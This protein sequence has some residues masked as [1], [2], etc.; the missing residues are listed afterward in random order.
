MTRSASVAILPEYLLARFCHHEFRR[1]SRKLYS[2]EVRFPPD[3][4]KEPPLNCTFLSEIATLFEKS[5]RLTV[6]RDDE[7]VESSAPVS[8]LTE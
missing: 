3:F 4:W 6:P 7:F 1:F 2:D 8:L 5:G